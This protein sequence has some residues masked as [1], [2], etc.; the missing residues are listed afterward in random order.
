MQLAGLEQCPHLLAIPGVQQLRREAA[1]AGGEVVDVAQQHR[2][3][4]VVAGGADD[5]REI[6]DDRTVGPDQHVVGRQVAMDQAAA[7]HQLHLAHQHGVVVA[8]LPRFQF[9]LAQARRAVALCV[10][11]QFHHQ[12]A[13]EVAERL[14]HAHAGRAQLVQRLDLGVLPGRLL[15]LA[16]VLGG[17]ADRA[18]LTAAAHLAAFLVLHALLEA[19]LGHVL[20]DLRAAHLTAAAD[21][22]DRRFL[23]A[24][25]RPQHFVDDAVVDQRL[26]AWGCSHGIPGVVAAAG[27]RGRGRAIF[28][29]PSRRGHRRATGAHCDP[30]AAAAGPGGVRCH[31]A[32]RMRRA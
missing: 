30:L 4:R 1:Q 9:D 18:R 25:E 12:H 19:A 3:R 11:D 2:A 23:A 16:P 27:R 17:L 29:P 26:Q 6:D 24:L 7:Q 32:L 14:G 5:L 10:G 28:A 8:G 15:L 21:H 20:V 22:V 13:M 31:D